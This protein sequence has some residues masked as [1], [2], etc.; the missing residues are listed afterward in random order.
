MTAFLHYLGML[1]DCLLLIC[2]QDQQLL[3]EA[4][5]AGLC[6]TTVRRTSLEDL[7]SQ[8]IVL[9]TFLEVPYMFGQRS[10]GSLMLVG[11]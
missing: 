3:S 4:E 11:K 5:I 2:L 10:G 7:P 1:V 8:L 6:T 9:S